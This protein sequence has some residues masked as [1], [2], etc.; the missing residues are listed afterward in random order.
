MIADYAGS[1]ILTLMSIKF[2]RRQ[3]QVKWAVREL[4]PDHVR[5]SGYDL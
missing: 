1:P 4:D 3:K 2:I 5:P